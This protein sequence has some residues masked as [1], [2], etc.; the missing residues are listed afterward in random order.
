MKENDN[1]PYQKILKD[2]ECILRTAY[3]ANRSMLIVAAKLSKNGILDLKIETTSDDMFQMI[4][5]G[6]MLHRIKAER[7]ITTEKLLRI[8][9]K[10]IDNHR[11][12]V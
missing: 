6:A 1:Y 3:D 10:I 12:E 5:I 8:L 7:T 2:I 9:G 4:V 11:E